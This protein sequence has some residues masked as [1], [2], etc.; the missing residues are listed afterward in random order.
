[1]QFYF[2]AMKTYIEKA[3]GNHIYMTIEDA[4]EAR[5]WINGTLLPPYQF[6]VFQAEAVN[7]RPSG[8][9]SVPAD[10]AA[11]PA[12]KAQAQSEPTAVTG[13]TAEHHR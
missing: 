1:M 10:A 2:V 3:I 8:L 7:I 6:Q 9:T 5:D 12:A 13:G 4:V 11:L